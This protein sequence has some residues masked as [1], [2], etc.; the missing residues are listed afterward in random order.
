MMATRP[1][2]T[3][4]NAQRE[5][6]DSLG[7]LAA[8]GQSGFASYIDGLLKIRREGQTSRFP[9]EIATALEELRGLHA[10][11]QQSGAG[12]PAPQ[13]EDVRHLVADDNFTI[14]NQR[15]PYIAKKLKD[16]WGTCLFSPFINELFRDS[17]GGTRQGFTKEVSA[18]L[19]RLHQ[20]HDR[21][22]P[23]TV[24]ELPDIWSLKRKAP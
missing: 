18:A 13:V 12:A 15:H 2:S 4:Q 17:R 5:M 3:P 10:N 1:I 11:A 7:H 14:V 23:E 9:S 8:W 19:F 22:F 21:L 16:A 24:R 20:E 6:F